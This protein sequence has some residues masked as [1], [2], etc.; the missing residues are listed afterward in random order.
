MSS[1]RVSDAYIL[2]RPAVIRGLLVVNLVV[3][4]GVRLDVPGVIVGNLTVEPGG[5]AVIHGTVSGTVTNLGGCVEVYGAADALR[6]L[7]PDNPIR[8]AAGARIG[9]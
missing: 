6:D 3:P 2:T 7:D 1:T 5:T 9:S 8:V 4:A